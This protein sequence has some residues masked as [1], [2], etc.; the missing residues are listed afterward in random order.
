VAATSWACRLRNLGAWSLDIVTLA[1]AAVGALGGC[2]GFYALWM[3]R[4]EQ[5]ERRRE[6][7]V[8]P[9]LRPFLVDAI[10]VARQVTVRPRD[11]E[12]CRE[13]AAPLWER[14]GVL[15][16]IMKDSGSHIAFERLGAQ[17]AGLETCAHD[18]LVSGT[19]QEAAVRA[20]KQ[21][22]YAE[23]ALQTASQLL[24]RLTAGRL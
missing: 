7:R 6:G 19:E 24:A 20:V 14:H 8:P 3:Q 4:Q 18:A 17:I 22:E 10:D 16:H 2:A 12:W 11:R 1:I 21:R 23:G 13:H 9:E 15:S 5:K